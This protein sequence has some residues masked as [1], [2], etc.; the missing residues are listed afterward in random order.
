MPIIPIYF[1]ALIFLNKPPLSGKHNFTTDVGRW[2]LSIQLNY[3][4]RISQGFLKNKYNISA[5]K[6]LWLYHVH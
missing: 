3:N 6:K 2:Q 1:N 5:L 4:Q